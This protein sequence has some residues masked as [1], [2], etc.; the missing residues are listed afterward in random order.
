MTSAVARGQRRCRRARLGSGT[1][2]ADPSAPPRAGTAEPAATTDEARAA[3]QRAAEEARRVAQRRARCVRVVLARAAAVAR[4]SRCSSASG[5]WSSHD[6]AAAAVAGEDVWRRR[7]SVFGDPFYRKGPNDQGIGWNILMLAA[8]RRHRLRPRRA[9]R[10]S[11][12]LHPRPLRV[13]ERDGRADHQ[14]AAPGVA[15]RV[16]ADRPPGVQGRESGGD[17]GDLHLEHLA[18]DHQH[19]GRRAARAAGLPQ[20]RAR[21]EPLRME[22]RHADPVPGGAAVHADRRAPCRSASRGSSSSPPRC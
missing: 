22:G 18:D 14:P 2:D 8:A 10:H 15:A 5:R 12:R 7:S 4:R 6:V 1:R 19:R 16:A 21:A 13:P 11:A 3:P 9:G 20:R 17:L